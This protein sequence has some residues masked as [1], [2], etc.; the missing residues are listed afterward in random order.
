MCPALSFSTRSLFPVS[1]N[2]DLPLICEF[3]KNHKPKKSNKKGTTKRPRPRTQQPPIVITVRPQRTEMRK[4]RDVESTTEMILSSTEGDG[5][6]AISSTSS[7]DSSAIQVFDEEEVVGDGVTEGPE[8]SREEHSIGFKPH[9][10]HKTRETQTFQAKLSA[11]LQVQMMDDNQ[12]SSTMDPDQFMVNMIEEQAMNLT[13]IELESEGQQQI[14]ISPQSRFAMLADGIKE[15]V[16]NELGGGTSAENST[17]ESGGMAFEEFMD[18]GFYNTSDIPISESTRLQMNAT[19]EVID[20]AVVTDVNGAQDTSDSKRQARNATIAEIHQTLNHNESFG[21]L[22]KNFSSQDYDTGTTSSSF[23]EPTEG[24]AVKL[25][26]SASEEVTSNPDG[27]SSSS[28]V[29]TPML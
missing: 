4:K 7:T 16:G 20:S 12:V 19:T 5:Q 9:I 28:S 24:Y 3:D 25:N 18:T 8:K 27:N 17:T 1:C 26:V 29:I 15:V 2:T 6:L 11:S 22:E 21:D 10:E 23:L 13:A 14:S